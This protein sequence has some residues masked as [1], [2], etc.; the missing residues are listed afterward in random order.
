MA[1]KHKRVRARVRGVD[2][3]DLTTA[4]AE[5]RVKYGPQV[6]AVKGL[7][8]EARATYRGDVEAARAGAGAAVQAAKAARK[9]LARI[10][11][12]AL[13]SIGGAESDVS[14]SFAHLG[15]AADP[16]RAVTAREQGGYRARTAGAKV[17]ALKELTDRQLEA[18]AGRLYAL[19]QASGNRNQT[20]ATLNSR[21]AGL[22]G[23]RQSYLTGLLG[24][25]REQRADRQA[26][27]QN[28]RIQGQES[29]K[30][31]RLS[32][33][34]E[35]QNSAASDAR[36][37]AQKAA[38]KAAGGGSKKGP[39]NAEVRMFSTELNR[40]VQAVNQGRYR[41]GGKPRSRAE[42]A[43]ALTAG[44]PGKKGVRNAIP[45]AKDDLALSVALDMAFK[46][47]VTPPNLKRM[48]AQRLPVRRFPNLKRRS[49]TTSGAYG[50]GALH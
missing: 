29:R 42:I 7:K 16:Y 41:A 28:L 45:G 2:P 11:E 12:D 1:R 40:L 13:H 39:S 36:K 21:L 27:R 5:T 8:R 17:S 14:S 34:L 18:H 44:I 4:I 49:Q 3:R 23:E 10:Y 43:T 26:A 6:S 37:A 46:G 47:Y 32:K 9:P 19:Q 22:L 30:S 25:A 38:D 20:V 35:A 48:K 15:S 24:Q 50:M 31:T 33:R